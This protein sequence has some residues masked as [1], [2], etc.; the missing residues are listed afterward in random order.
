VLR[1]LAD[2]LL[3]PEG[4]LS[5]GLLE[6]GPD[7]RI[8]RIASETHPEARRL[9]GFVV[10]GV[11]NLHSH[12]FQRALAGRAEHRGQSQTDSF[13]TWREAMYALALR[14]SPEQVRAIA[15][16]LYV[17]CLEAGMTGVGEFHY[18]HHA[19]DGGRYAE[20]AE[21][22]L[23]LL[24]A[25]KDAGLPI[26]LLP[27]LYVA[28]GF[29]RPPGERQRRFTCR[30][31]DELLGLVATLRRAAAEHPE[32]KVGLAPHSLR[33]APPEALLPAVAGL[34][35][36]DPEA[37][38]HVHAAE[39]PQEVEDCLAHLKARPV[40]WLVDTAGAD[41]RWCLVHATHTTPAETAALAKS[42]AVA[43][44][45][46]T[47]E[48]NLGDGLFDAPAFLA[49]GGRF[50]VGSDSH[51]TVSAAEELRLLEYGQRLVHRQRN[52]LAGEGPERHVGRHLYAA[53]ARGGAQALGQPAGALQVGLRA[54]LVVLDPEH[55][56][57]LGHGPETALDAFVFGDAGG[58]VSEVYVAGRRV[59][60]GGRHLRRDEVRARFAAAARALY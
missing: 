55:P 34:L 31:P 46:L 44:L 13:W 43:G 11:P 3:T 22:G 36:D 47:T 14:V 50:G 35:A 53:A 49:A 18:L 24:E 30:G 7:G 32:A 39:Q 56:R 54:D 57:L 42:G 15:A 51:V 16:Q 23:Q 59:V 52:L 27:A 40:E 10:P 17:E 19:P 29:G 33:A 48:A 9:A 1:L 4:W 37:R 6:V 5:P 20:P 41:H 2:H 28:G 12:A 21:M 26:T 58:A 38:I 25:A 60:A 45:C 8:T